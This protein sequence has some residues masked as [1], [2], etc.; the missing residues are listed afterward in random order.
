ME[1]NFFGLLWVTQAA[2]TMFRQQG[3]G[4]LLQMSS[5]AGLR[6]APLDGVYAASK[7]AVE[8]LSD[9]V[10]AETA[11]L[12]IRVTIVEPGVVATGF[13]ERARVDQAGLPEYEEVHRQY[14]ERVGSMPLRACHETT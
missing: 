13:F 6:A 2:L 3:G 14:S 4:H 5:G 10:A 1:T 11:G 9:A 7:W 8:G 12:G